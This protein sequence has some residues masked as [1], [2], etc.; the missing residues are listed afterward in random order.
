MNDTTGGPS[1]EGA[2]LNDDKVML[3]LED[4]TG[5]L[6]QV[7]PDWIPQV[8]PK[9]HVAFGIWVV[10]LLVISGL[11]INLLMALTR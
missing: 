6:D 2:V 8:T 9:T 5:G 4:P 7:N 3:D 1:R 11:V 10:L